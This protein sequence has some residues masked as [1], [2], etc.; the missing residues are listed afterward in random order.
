MKSITDIKDIKNKRVVKE[1]AMKTIGQWP[2]TYK[3][4]KQVYKNLTKRAIGQSLIIQEE[5]MIRRMLTV[6]LWCN[7]FLNT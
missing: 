3:Y 1:Y 7:L 4:L 5:V 6:K 2:R